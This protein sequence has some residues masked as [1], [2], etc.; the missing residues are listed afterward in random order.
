MHLYRW[1]CSLS[2]TQ[3]ILIFKLNIHCSLSSQL[4][5]TFTAWFLLAGVNT[6]WTY[7]TCENGKWKK[8]GTKQP[9]FA[10][11]Q[12]LNLHPPVQNTVDTFQRASHFK[13]SKLEMLQANSP[14]QFNDKC[15]RKK[16]NSNTQTP[17]KKQNWREKKNITRHIHGMTDVVTHRIIPKGTLNTNSL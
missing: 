12:S 8:R 11:H 2:N 10:W 4:Q 6:R 16:L 17:P 13:V 15:L 3:D 14:Y 9:Q 7:W 1:R 5:S